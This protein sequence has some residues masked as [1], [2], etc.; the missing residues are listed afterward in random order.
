MQKEMRAYRRALVGATGLSKDNATQ[1][2]NYATNKKSNSNLQPLWAADNLS[3]GSSYQG[4]RRRTQ[5]VPST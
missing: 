5:R 2:C 3:K 4:K 1:K